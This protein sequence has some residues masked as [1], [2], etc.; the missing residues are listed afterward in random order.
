MAN[1]KV[2]KIKH[3][4]KAVSMPK[5]SVKYFDEYS[6]LFTG[7]LVP[8][9]EAFFENLIASM[10]AHVAELR[11]DLLTERKNRYSYTVEEFYDLKKIPE[12]TQR[13][14]RKKHSG[15]QE[16]HAQMK[17][18]LGRLREAGAIHG[19]FKETTINRS[20][21]KYS[22]IVNEAMRETA[23]INAKELASS[24]AAIQ[25]VFEELA[26]VRK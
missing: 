6:E 10:E 16:A 24:V 14:W 8:M 19:D 11:N 13:Q 17:Y 7:R 12:T 9:P 23:Q 22:R 20:L 25:E 4:I 15:L 26:A 2:K 1:L 18:M 3:S 5:T 21:H